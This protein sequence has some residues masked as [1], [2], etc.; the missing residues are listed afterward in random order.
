MVVT[1][2][3]YLFTA[4]QTDR[5]TQLLKDIDLA[6]NNLTAF[7]VGGSVMVGFSLFVVVYAPSQQF[8][9]SYCGGSTAPEEH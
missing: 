1:F 6:W 8:L 7:L 2:L 9:K 5:L 4:V 3:L